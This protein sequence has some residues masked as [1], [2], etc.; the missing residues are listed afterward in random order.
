MNLQQRQEKIQAKRKK[1]P[2]RDF[3]RDICS[4]YNVNLYKNTGV[5]SRFP[6]TERS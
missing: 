1:T 5:I 6:E 3:V 2:W 4:W